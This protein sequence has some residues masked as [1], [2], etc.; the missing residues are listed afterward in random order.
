MFTDRRGLEKKKGKSYQKD[1]MRA[2]GFGDRM[3]RTGVA[4]VDGRMEG[5][6]WCVGEWRD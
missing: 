2:D 3:Y 4:G 1:T 6:A 5:A